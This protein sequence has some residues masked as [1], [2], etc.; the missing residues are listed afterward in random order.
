MRIVSVLADRSQ[1]ESLAA[2]L[3][4]TLESGTLDPSLLPLAADC[5]TYLHSRFSADQD[6]VFAKA[7]SGMINKLLQTKDTRT[8]LYGFFLAE[9]AS[10]Q[11]TADQYQKLLTSEVSKIPSQ[12]A[13]MWMLNQS[14]VVNAMWLAT[15]ARNRLLALDRVLVQKVNDNQSNLKN[16]YDYARQ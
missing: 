15:R 8:K 6:E 9:V 1:A 4:A 5:V 16:V 12:R 3:L 14:V 7:A 13:D 10:I 2:S 11:L